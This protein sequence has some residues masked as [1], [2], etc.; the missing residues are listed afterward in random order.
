MLASSF[1]P[2]KQPQKQPPILRINISENALNQSA[3]ESTGFVIPSS[4][5]KSSVFLSSLSDK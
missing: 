3:V 1:A 4:E 5:R 2:R